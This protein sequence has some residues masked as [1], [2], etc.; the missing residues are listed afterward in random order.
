M[1]NGKEYIEKLKA[2]YENCGLKKNWDGLEK[3][4]TGITDDNKQKLLSEYP[5]FPDT[6]MQILQ[7][8]DGT[9]WRKYGNK[10]ITYYFFGS[11]VDEGEYPYY[12]FSA[13]QMLE[14]KDVAKNF[15]DLIEYFL[16]NVENA[17]ELY[18]DDRIQT[19]VSKM[20]WLCFS[21]CMNNGGTS[22]LYIDFTP[23]EK[24]TK[25]QII[26]YL[27]DPDELKVIANSFDEYLDMLI[28]NGFKFINEYDFE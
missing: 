26:R 18:F 9:Y 3:I 14:Q 19:D 5:E 4:A 23:S 10:K 12:L 28:K 27:H 1:V 8:I 16:E 7:K 11:D 15:A 22:S 20:K 13:E 25:G 6:L 2:A 17:Y 21:D 24:G